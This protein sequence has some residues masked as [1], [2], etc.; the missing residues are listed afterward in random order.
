M[1]LAIVWKGWSK[2]RKASVRIVSVFEEIQT[3]NFPNT[4]LERYRYTSR[5]V[6]FP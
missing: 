4:R 3:E 2:P 5:L 1:N 6:K